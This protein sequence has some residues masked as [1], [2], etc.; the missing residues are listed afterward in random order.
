M[1]KIM[2]LKDSLANAQRIYNSWPKWKRECFKIVKD[3]DERE[4]SGG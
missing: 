4:Y 1:I 2:S 3:E